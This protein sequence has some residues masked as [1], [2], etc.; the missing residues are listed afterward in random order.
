[1][2]NFELPRGSC[3]SNMF[4]QLDLPPFLEVRQITA[5]GGIGLFAKEPVKRGTKL[6]SREI[7]V[8]GVSGLTVD[9]LRS[10]CHYC[11]CEVGSTTPIVCRGC[12][13]ISYCSRDCLDADR[14]LHTMECE[15]IMELEKLRGKVELDG[16][17]GGSWPSDTKHYWP[18]VHALLV[19]RII[20]KGIL[21]GNQYDSGWIDCV[22]CPDTL[23]PIKSKAFPSMERYVR[24]LVPEEI[25]DKEIERTF[26]V[27]SV[28]ANTV[29][30]PACT[31]VIAVYNAE[32]SLLSH[33]CK[34]NCVV[35]DE[36]GDI[37]VYSLEDLQVGV[38]LGIS[39]VLKEYYLNV[40]EVRR[41]KLNECF[42]LDCHCFVCQGETIPG[43]KLWL[44]EEQKSSLITPWSHA[45]V[46]KTMVSGWGVLCDCKT[47]S[48]LTPSQV[49]E[50]L[51][52][53]LAAQKIVLDK[54]NVML[55]LTAMTLI[56]NHCKLEESQMA[57]D[58]YYES[59]GHVGMTSL[60]E[61]G[62]AKD[63]YEIT[64]NVCVSLLDLGRMAEFNGMFKLT[65]QFHP[66]QPSCEALCEM[67]GLDV[68]QDML[69][70]EEW[71][72]EDDMRRELELRATRRG[73]PRSFFNQFIDEFLNQ[74]DRRPSMSEMIE[75]CQ[76]IMDA[77]VGCDCQGQV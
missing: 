69:T 4:R 9:N 7:H 48:N 24:L 64:G 2:K 51:E 71:E 57:V 3:A 65:Q 16:V 11:L 73:I 35:E 41:A 70:A 23:P 68:P 55:I 38:Q 49:S 39:F 15:G 27:V 13:I 31:S 17:Q 42:G 6:F 36:E 54:R 63:V 37:A 74:F 53:S 62:T 45:M 66:R 19:A 43:S 72:V 14:S 67:L 61:Y 26:R 10:V 77:N 12:R 32:Y 50:M 18:P 76:D 75:A 58:I 60:M 25:S 30:S 28:N 40:R 47:T 8:L 56:L 1:M 34:P 22:R 46:R 59:L 33:M 20:N 29:S 21:T 5:D 44:L 52:S